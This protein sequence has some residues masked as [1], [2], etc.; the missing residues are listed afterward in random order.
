MA[1]AAHTVKIISIFTVGPIKRLVAK[2]YICPTVPNYYGAD[3]ENV[4]T[5]FTVGPWLGPAV[6]IIHLI[7]PL[8]PP[9]T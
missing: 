6:K 2:P 8:P 7:I 1:R 4:K 9:P 3:G 5:I